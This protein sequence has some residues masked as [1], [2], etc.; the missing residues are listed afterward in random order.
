M[1]LVTVVLVPVVGPSD[2]TNASSSRFGPVVENAAVVTAL[3]AALASP[4]AVVSI[5]RPTALATPVPVNT[6]DPEVAGAATFTFRDAAIATA[7]F[8]VKVTLTVQLAPAARFAGN[9]VAQVS[10]AALANWAAF[11]P[12]GAMPVMLI[13]PVPVFLT[14]TV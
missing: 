10:P 9:T 4:N 11:V 14:V 2:D 1:T 5:A 12:V 3:P 13:V 6:T 8:G 7:A